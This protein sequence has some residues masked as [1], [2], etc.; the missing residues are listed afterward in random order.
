MVVSVPSEK[1]LLWHPRHDNKFVVGG[2]SQITLYEWAPDHPEIR[3]V[4]S[5]HDI[6]FMKVT[7]FQFCTLI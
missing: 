2:G 3:H 7:A 1:R 6:Q 4:T 5:Q